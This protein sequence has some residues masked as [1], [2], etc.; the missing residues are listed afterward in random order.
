[1]V[2][3]QKKITEI[4]KKHFLI[5]ISEYSPCMNYSLLSRTIAYVLKSDM[6]SGMKTIPRTRKHSRLGGC[7]CSTSLALSLRAQLGLAIY[8]H[9]A[10]PEIAT[11]TFPGDAGTQPELTNNYIGFPALTTIGAFSGS[12]PF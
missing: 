3:S 2:K 1:M 10:P 4:G 7:A 6:S 5:L 12:Q 8:P 9:F 11:S